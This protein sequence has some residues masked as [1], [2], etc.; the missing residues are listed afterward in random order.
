[1]TDQFVG[2]GL[3]IV[4][5]VALRK[6]EFHDDRF[7]QAALVHLALAGTLD[8][9]FPDHSR[10]LLA[11]I[12]AGHSDSR[13]LLLPADVRGLEMAAQLVVLSGTAVAGSSRS[14]ADSRLAFVAD[15][16][17]AGCK[18]VLVSYLPAGERM[19][20]DFT[21]D[22]Y[23]RLLS[24]P[25]IETALANSKRD[26]IKVGSGTNLPRWAGFQLFIR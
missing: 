6:D 11:P 18:A 15:F 25:A 24:D 19:G 14:L 10:L 26:Q 21:T 12:G 17:E 7:A 5:G 8:L 22:L 2:P 1:V 20:G 13:S 23:R 9:A 3:H 16:L 4:Q